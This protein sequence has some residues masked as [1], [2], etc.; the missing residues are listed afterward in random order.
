MF[1]YD[2]LPQLEALVHTHGE[3]I[4]MAHLSNGEGTAIEGTTYEQL[5]S[6]DD[7]ST[8]HLLCIVYIDG[9]TPKTNKS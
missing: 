6:Q 5:L 3:A 8:I 4:H 1:I 7:Q 2:V 9:V